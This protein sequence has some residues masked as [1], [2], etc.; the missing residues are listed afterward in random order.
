MASRGYRRRR[1]RDVHPRRRRNRIDT[2]SKGVVDPYQRRTL[3]LIER[4]AKPGAG[5]VTFTETCEAAATE[6]RSTVLT[7]PGTSWMVWD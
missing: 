2:V 1:C 3:N 4:S 6:P 7:W 5:N